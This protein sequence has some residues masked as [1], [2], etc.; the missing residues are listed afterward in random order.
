MRNVKNAGVP[1][2]RR[3]GTTKRDD[4]KQDRLYVMA[5]W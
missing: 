2:A 5:W 3:D 4:E 1:R